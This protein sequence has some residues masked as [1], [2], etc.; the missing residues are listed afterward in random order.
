[1]ARVSSLKQATLHQEEDVFL[2]LKKG[3]LA[4]VKAAPLMLSLLV[5]W[6]WITGYTQ[7]W[8]FWPT[9]VASI[10]FNF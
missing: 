2:S 10:F 1:M 5:S 9:L 3:K 4:Y 6:V 8:S 7:Q